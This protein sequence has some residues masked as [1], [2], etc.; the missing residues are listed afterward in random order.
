MVCT[1][2]PLPRRESCSDMAPWVSEID[3]PTTVSV[4]LTDLVPL[5]PA[6]APNASAARARA[7]AGS[8]I[9]SSLRMRRSSSHRDARWEFLSRA[10][11]HSAQVPV[12][13][14]PHAELAPALG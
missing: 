10:E 3:A 7:R 5:A 1:A 14:S 8:V 11:G 13:G 4:N 12:S 2:A 9:R 6:F